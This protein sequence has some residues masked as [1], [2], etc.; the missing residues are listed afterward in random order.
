VQT[1]ENCKRALAALVI[2]I[3]DHSHEITPRSLARGEGKLLPPE[4]PQ[5]DHP[6]SKECPGPRK[7]SAKCRNQS[8]GPNDGLARVSP[9]AARVVSRSCQ[10]ATCHEKKPL[11]GDSS[12]ATC[13]KRGCHLSDIFKDTTSKPRPVSE[14]CCLSAILTV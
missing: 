14:V 3:R 5:V 11:W 10:G 6:C 8:R 13:N 1:A 2:P 12:Q 9:Y 7:P 4:R